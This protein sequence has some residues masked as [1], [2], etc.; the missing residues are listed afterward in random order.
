MAMGLLGRHH[1]GLLK[2]IRVVGVRLLGQPMEGKARKK[3]EMVDEIFRK[4]EA[5]VIQQLI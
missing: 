3:Q 2:D 1:F 4:V 5:C